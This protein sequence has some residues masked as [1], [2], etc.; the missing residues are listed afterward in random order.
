MPIAVRIEAKVW[1]SLCGRE[2]FGQ[3]QL[4]ALAQQLV[5]AL[6]DLAQNPLAQV[7]ALAPPAG[8]RREGDGVGAGGVRACLV[9][10]ED[11][12]EDRQDPDLAQAG[13]GLRAADEDAH[14][15]EVD[16]AFEHVAELVGAG[17]GEDQGGDDRFALAAQAT[18]VAVEFG[19]GVEQRLD[20]LGGVE[21]DRRLGPRL[22]QAVP[23]GR[24]VLGDPLVLDGQAEEPGEN[25][26]RLV[27]RGRRQR[28][29][30]AAV[31]V[32][33]GIAAVDRRLQP[34][35]FFDLRGAVGVDRFGVDC[36]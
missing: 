14:V 21:M 26:D 18:G 16:V 28:L 10:G 4:A 6:E 24:R 5:G 30:G 22:Q 31:L 1:R 35:P 32:A 7:A 20:L 8:A 17:A 19:G 3:R 36:S 15:G 11:V 2:P 33:V 29:A 27:D 34:L 23:T 13:R 25:L 9:G 12:V